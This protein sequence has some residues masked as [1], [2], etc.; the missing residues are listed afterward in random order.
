MEGAV[1]GFAME[2]AVLAAFAAL[3]LLAAEHQFLAGDA[4]FKLLGIDAGKFRPH[5]HV[6]LAFGNID[7]RLPG[8]AASPRPRDARKRLAGESV[9]EPVHFSAQTGQ[10]VRFALLAAALFCSPRNQVDHENF[11]LCASEGGSPRFFVRAC[12]ARAPGTGDRPQVTVLQVLCY[13]ALTVMRRGFSAS[14][15]GK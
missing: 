13:S 8:A 15:L 10:R 7:G 12:F 11:L 9:Q 1:A 3:L 5:R 2:V 14:T 6:L 4:D